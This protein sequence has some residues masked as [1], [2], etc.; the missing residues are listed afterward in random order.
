MQ[1]ITKTKSPSFLDDKFETRTSPE[2]GDAWIRGGSSDATHI[3][4]EG[5]EVWKHLMVRRRIWFR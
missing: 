1:L 3:V 5:R 4:E 2:V